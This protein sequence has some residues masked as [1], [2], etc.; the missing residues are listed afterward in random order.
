MKL[1]GP[2]K[3][4]FRCGKEKL[5][6]FFSKNCSRPDGL[7]SECKECHRT[8]VRE[9]A[10]KNPDKMRKWRSK[11]KDKCAG[12]AKKFMSTPP[13][14]RINRANVK[15]AGDRYYILH[16][17]GPSVIDKRCPRCQE[18][19]EAKMFSLDR[20]SPSGLNWICKKCQK[21]KDAE[22]ASRKRSA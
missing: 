15:K 1:Y 5:R 4:C 7:G 3:K 17:A 19:K 10:R 14:R 20:R 18:T 12:Y 2:T 16:K 21:T 11:N 6:Y 9:W 8:T 22:Y 13:G